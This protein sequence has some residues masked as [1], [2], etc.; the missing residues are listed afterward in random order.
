LETFHV[1]QVKDGRTDT[2]ENMAEVMRSKLHTHKPAKF[3]MNSL[4][5]NSG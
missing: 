5:K 3:Q 4:P 2:Y 1:I